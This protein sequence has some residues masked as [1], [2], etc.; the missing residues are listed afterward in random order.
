[1]AEWIYK[2]AENLFLFKFINLAQELSWMEIFVKAVCKDSYM[3]IPLVVETYDTI[4]KVKAKIQ[5]R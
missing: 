4:E 5:V 2:L 3:T 1:M